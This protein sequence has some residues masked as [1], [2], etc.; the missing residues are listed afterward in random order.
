MCITEKPLVAQFPPFLVTHMPP[1]DVVSMATGLSLIVNST[2][3]RRSAGSA[4][5]ISSSLLDRPGSIVTAAGIR[6][7]PVMLTPV[8]TSR[9]PRASRAWWTRSLRASSSSNENG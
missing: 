9:K 4:E 6:P 2:L 7:A 1:N 5:R 3:E 8:T